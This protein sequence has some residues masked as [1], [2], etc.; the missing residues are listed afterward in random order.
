MN[1]GTAFSHCARLHSAKTAVFWGD[2]ELSYGQIL[3]Q[4]RGVAGCLRTRLDLKNGDRVGI[5]LKNCPEFIPALMGI[6]LA[7]GVVVPINNFLK[8]QEVA[9]ILNDAGIDCLLTQSGFAE[10]EPG[11]AIR[12]AGRRAIVPRF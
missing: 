8:P 10:F 9:H 2:A 5:W 7:G 11:L 6:W 4:A 3:D 1:L 12:S